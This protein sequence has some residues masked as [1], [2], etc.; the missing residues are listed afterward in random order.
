MIS[1]QAVKELRERTGAGMMDCKKALQETNGD[2]E[3]AVEYLR[4]KGLAAAAKKAGRIAAEGI[5]TSY[6]HAGGRVGVLVEINCETDFV[7]KTE[8]FQQLGK[9]IAMQIA[10]SKPQYVRRE[11]VPADV[12]E[13]EKQIL[14]AQ[15]LNEGKPENIVE[16]MVEGRIEKFYKEVC[17]LEQPF[18]KNPD[19]TIE[20]LIKEKIAKIGENINVRRFVRYEMGEGLE[21]RQ[22]DFAAEVMKEL[23]R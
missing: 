3:K 23:Q 1:A 17:L 15:A 21:K 19:I 9:D 14:R 22:D 2:M 16:K 7:A 18:V 11:E 20:Q 12:I 8:E 13:K 6:I 4:E 10:A 5:V